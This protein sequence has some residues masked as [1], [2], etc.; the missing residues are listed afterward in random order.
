M[1]SFKRSYKIITIALITI[2]LSVFLVGG[3]KAEGGVGGY[4]GGGGDVGFVFVVLAGIGYVLFDAPNLFPYPVSVSTGEVFTIRALPPVHPWTEFA[5]PGSF[6]TIK[7]KNGLLAKEYYVKAPDQ[8]GLYPYQKKLW[9][10]SLGYRMS[11][12]SDLETRAGVVNPTPPDFQRQ[13]LIGVGLQSIGFILSLGYL[14]ADEFPKDELLS[15]QGI[16]SF[17][18]GSLSYYVYSQGVGEGK[19]TFDNTGSY[20]LLGTMAFTSW[21][22]FRIINAKNEYAKEVRLE[23]IRIINEK[24][25]QDNDLEL[26]YKN[27]KEL[28]NKLDDGANLDQGINK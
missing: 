4:P 25:K 21:D 7:I 20:L 14:Y 23:N 8:R 3:V 18:M 12:L 13:P 1:L 19:S 27:M 9:G 5:F 11:V 28:Q 26:R 2:F 17:L 10:I 6:S 16:K 15:W 22:V 24:T